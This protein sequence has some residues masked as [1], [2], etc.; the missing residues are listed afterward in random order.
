MQWR[1]SEQFSG[2]LSA[3]MRLGGGLAVLLTLGALTSPAR[4]GEA[5][6]AAPPAPDAAAPSTA[7]V[8]EK[9]APISPAPR[10]DWAVFPVVLYAPETSLALLGG[11]AFFDDTPKA[12]GEQRRDDSI[13]IGVMGTLRKQYQLTVSGV[14]F[15]DDA[16]W[17]LTEDAAL[18]SFPNAYWGIGNDTPDEAREP[19]TQSGVYS[20]VTLA[21]VAFE[22]LYVGAGLTTAWYDI[23][24]YPAAGAVDDYLGTA[25]RSGPAV[26][27]GP[28]LRRDTR[29]DA[30]GAHRGSISSF[31][32]TF[33]PSALGSYRYAFYEL[34]HR[35]HFQLGSRTVLAVEAYGA[36][37]PGNVPL[38]EMPALGGSSRLR[39]YF[40]GRYRDHLYLM[41]QVEW[42]I[43]VYGRFSVAP[44]GGVGNVF[45]S[46]SAIS[47]ENPKYAGG[48]SVRFNLKKERDLNVHVDVAVSPDGWSPY[49][50]MGEAF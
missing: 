29:D 2:N 17:Q 24:G 23:T 41:G 43:R 36:W 34:D 31:A 28:I 15:W 6:P 3:T 18:V 14:K 20:R 32:A 30:L 49:L 45:A 4:A 22:Q 35:S 13:A 39:G 7:P 27:I 1:R 19:F 50:T 33:F 9:P 16:R 12:P 26:G 21:R 11:V 40:N 5:A 10:W 25:P 38:A 42:R 46:P 44:F 37:A 8:T 48:L 47:L